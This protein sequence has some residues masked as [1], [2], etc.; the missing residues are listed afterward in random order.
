M[1]I[2]V[3]AVVFEQPDGEGRA[4]RQVT[5]QARS[6]AEAIEHVTRMMAKESVEVHSISRKD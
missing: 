3:I 5:V 2:Y 6:E 4:T 1:M